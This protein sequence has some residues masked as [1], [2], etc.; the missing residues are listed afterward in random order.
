M[1]YF[2]Y[3]LDQIL[4][5]KKVALTRLFGLLLWMVCSGLL[6]QNQIKSIY[7]L[8]NETIT[9]IA[10]DDD[11]A[12]W[13]ST[14]RGVIKFSGSYS[15]YYFPGRQTDNS[16]STANN[17]DLLFD[18]EGVL[19][20]AH[21]SGLDKIMPNKR[22]DRIRFNMNITPIRKLAEM[23]SVRMVISTNNGLSILD[24]ME[25]E[26]ICSYQNPVISNS[27][28][29]QIT[30]QNHIWVASDF[31]NVVMVFDDSLRV[32]R[33]LN[34]EGVNRIN[35]MSVDINGNLYFATDK[36]LFHIDSDTYNF[37]SLPDYI[38]QK[39]DGKNVLIVN[40]TSDLLTSIGIANEGLF[41]IYM[42]EGEIISIFPQEKLN[43]TKC[44]YF[45]DDRNS[46]WLSGETSGYNYYPK[47]TSSVV[48]YS[49]LIGAV[50]G[51]AT[52]KIFEDSD[53]NI[54]TLTN[55]RI[56][57]YDKNTNNVN[58]VS[59]P[60][61]DYKPAIQTMFISSDN[62][63]WIQI[64][65]NEIEEYRIADK[66]L[67]F[68]RKIPF[69]YAVR[70]FH[71]FFEED[72]D[73]NIYIHLSQ[74]TFIL[75]NAS[76]NFIEIEEIEGQKLEQPYRCFFNKKFNSTIIYGPE[77]ISLLYKKGKNRWNPIKFND[78]NGNLYRSF[79][80]PPY[81]DNDGELWFSNQR[82][83]Y[84]YDIKSGR[85]YVYG[86]QDG[87]PGNVMS[88]IKESGS[89]YMWIGT[90]SGLSRL[91]KK[92]GTIENFNIGREFDYFLPCFEDSEG[93]IYMSY[94]NGLTIIDPSDLSNLNNKSIPLIIESITKDNIEIGRVNSNGTIIFED[95]IVGKKTGTSIRLKH[96]ENNISFFFSGISFDNS[97]IEY[98]YKLEGYNS[99]WIRTG[100]NSA[101]YSSLKAG[102]YEFQVKIAGDTGNSIMK[103][104]FI[105]DSAP[106]FST[107][108]FVIYSI[109]LVGLVWTFFVI[110]QR[111]R[112]RIFKA[113]EK[114]M[115]EQLNETKIN[116]FTNISHEFRTP[117]SLIYAPLKSLG[118][119][120]LPEEGHNL[121]S[122]I[123]RNVQKLLRLTNQ[124]L[125]YNNIDKDYSRLYL[126]ERD[127][128]KVINETV[129]AFRY[130]AHEKNVRLSVIG[131]GSLRCFFDEVKLNR[132][133]SNIISNSIKYSPNGGDV[134]INVSILEN[135][136]AHE[137][138]P[139]LKDN[140]KFVEIS[141]LD[142]GIGIPEGKL[143]EIFDRY[144]RQV[145]DADITHISG[146]G[147]GL[148]YTK[149]LIEVHRGE[150]IAEHNQPNGS[151]FR[152]V[153]PLDATVYDNSEIVETQG[154][155]LPTMVPFDF[156]TENIDTSRKHSILVVEDDP[157][158]R[159]YIH[160]ILLPYYFVY[161]A[162]DGKLAL[163]VLENCPV[164]IIVADIMMPRM[165]G[166]N[167]C[168]TVR[169]KL[170][171]SNIS[172]IFLSGKSEIKDQING[173]SLGVDA[174][175]NKPFD[176]DYLVALVKNVIVNRERIQQAILQLTPQTLL[177][178]KNQVACGTHKDLKFIQ[179]IHEI[180]D[181]NLADVDFNISSMA[182]TLGMSRTG[183]YTKIK[184]L[185]GLK[186]IEFYNNYRLNKAA[187]Y[188]VTGEYTASEVGY[189]VGFSAL[190]SF[191]RSFQNKFG[192]TPKE[193]SNQHKPTYN[194]INPDIV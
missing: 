118:K 2:L 76:G 178:E 123:G 91:D 27:R 50:Q 193:Y 67:T 112:E 96:T 73:G 130:V 61:H 63:L 115:K 81:E 14:L 188:L 125:E 101:R 186:P 46:L 90:N 103:F 173:L 185:T 39:T 51:R 161:Q 189:M 190:Q 1:I 108:A 140:C 34:L 184:T 100:E 3:L 70:G 162:A 157:D 59:L 60:I 47:S 4:D 122:I 69:S 40:C 49:G 160:D 138:Y 89:S 110:A 166:Y 172:M 11:G 64:N 37:I 17:F 127:I 150:I 95:R 77:G 165:D 79:F 82:D 131:L 99:D 9:S 94:S 31:N 151:I 116:F 155:Q 176:P 93:I 33:S 58:E 114:E 171:W 132:I 15:T 52:T 164:D 106:W 18:S 12:I 144:H 48:R 21:Y 124:L 143:T 129:E 152:F 38:S 147:I 148:N 146:F 7:D 191:S 137:R 5:M 177:E 182:Q 97:L 55:N 117:L 68:V 44:I 62:R 43:T 20:V 83:L 134:L 109:I 84:R 119:I 175:V 121:I 36:G 149:Q 45:F 28:L 107:L 56:I 126:E 26:I 104:P 10:Q 145:V 179:Q 19:W 80:M 71:N 30:S 168:K 75:D 158:M 174:Y 133:L 25:E 29:L 180:M 169:D 78:R 128:V 32:L 35:D 120:D 72:Y 159:S 154:E 53:H 187:E 88:V 8:R 54:W 22:I 66:K 41:N 102:R 87:L 167:L 86:I 163:D 85:S 57:C 183:F 194:D 111:K 6:G 23:D 113:R 192:V 65:N 13:F 139:G 24:K 156:D 74:N 153:L 142:N 105:I 136:E 98:L 92:T 16:I 135:D 141:V 170:E 181:E 42:K